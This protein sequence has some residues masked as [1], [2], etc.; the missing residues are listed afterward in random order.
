MPLTKMRQPILV[1]KM[2]SREL[3]YPAEMV[4]IDRYSLQIHFGEAPNRQIKISSPETRFNEVQELFFAI[5]KSTVDRLTRFVNV[6]LEKFTPTANRLI[7]YGAAKS[8]VRIRPPMLE[9]DKGVFSSDPSDIFRD[10]FA[11]LCDRK[12]L[13]ISHIIAPD[14]LT[15]S[16]IDI[17]TQELKRWFSYYRFGSISKK[18]ETKIIRY[19]PKIDISIFEEKIRSLTSSSENNIAIGILPNQGTQYYYALKRLF[20]IQT[21]TPVQSIRLS[22]FN[23]IVNK[24][25]RGFKILS[26]KILVK[27]LKEGETIWRLSNAAGL[28]QERSLYVGIGF[29]RFPREKKVSKCAAVLHDARGSKVSWKVFATPQDRTITQQWF[30][31][32]LRRIQNFIEQENPTRLVFY[33]TGTLFEGEKEII[34]E[35]INSFSWLSETKVSFVSILDGS[36]YR[37]YTYD[38]GSNKY[39]NLPAGYAVIVNDSEALL[40]TSNYDERKLRQGTIVPVRLKLE[41][42]NDD[43]L[44]I[45]KEYHD[46]TYV[47]WLAPFTTSKTPSVTTI[48]NKFAELTREGVSAENFFYLDL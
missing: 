2:F 16:Y 14:F 27:S 39:G 36:N 28:L 44:D 33:R 43:I 42:G 3:H 8:I 35:V 24:R 10:D 29:S 41:L 13:S 46:Q 7:E 15:D 31:T 26:L 47:Y 45:V 23:D 21:K 12:N 32:L 20:P 38:R 19:D 30:K 48:A 17:F 11:P 5:K 9:F 25:F 40:S 22:T 4:Y 6:M 34:Q 37:L 18:Q 1:V